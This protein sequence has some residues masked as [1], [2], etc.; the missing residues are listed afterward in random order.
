MKLSF[1]FLLRMKRGCTQIFHQAMAGIQ[2][3]IILFILIN[4]W[5]WFKFIRLTGHKTFL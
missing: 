2:L 1:V 5:I 4:E 3:I